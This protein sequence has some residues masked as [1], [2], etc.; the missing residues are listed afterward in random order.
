MEFF[1]GDSKFLAR[2]FP[3]RRFDTDFPLALWFSGLWFYLKSFLYVCYV[4]MLG[5]EPAP[6][7]LWTWIEIGYFAGAFIPALLLGYAMWNEKKNLVWAAI[8]FL[9][10]DTPLLVFHVMKLGETGF[11]ESGLTKFLELGSLALNFVA[12]GWLIGYLTT[13]NTEASRRGS[14]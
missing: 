4:Y 11:L 1:M 8:L 10:I 7:E 9:L 13:K 5:T 14:V 2:W 12:L 3:L 6:Y